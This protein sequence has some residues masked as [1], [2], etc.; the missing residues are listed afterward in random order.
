L[1]VRAPPS[2]VE[3]E[4]V[5]S[6]TVQ[7]TVGQTIEIPFRGTGWVYL[8]EL[9]SK[10]GVDYVSRRTDPEG[11]SFVFRAA[12]PGTFE[13]KFMEQDFIRDYILNDHVRV[14][15]SEA[16]EAQS[17]FA[18]P[19]VDRGTVVASPRWPG[20]PAEDAPVPAGTALLEAAP[21]VLAVNVPD[22]TAPVAL[23][24]G[25]VPAAALPE[26]EDLSEPSVTPSA[27]VLSAS[28]LIESTPEEL[29]R[30]A[31]EALDTGGIAEGL[32]LLDR[33]REQFPA[34][35]D[36]AWWL[37]GQLLEANGPDRD[38]RAALDYYRRLVREYPQSPRY[39]EARRRI[40]YLERFYLNIR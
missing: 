23:A 38:I 11:Q 29:L 31:R 39:D 5:Y 6:R 12:S 37:Y 22:Q 18:A 26:S 13:L 34:G 9:H 10:P 1:P 14:I 2:I 35:S 19:P 7:A 30:Q 33:F 27:S 24:S 16:P 20:I 28:M 25:P 4:I 21:N 40:A 36:E 32:S 17:W 15:V 8:G 3:E